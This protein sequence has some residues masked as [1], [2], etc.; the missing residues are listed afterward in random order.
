[1]ASELN[2]N[3]ISGHTLPL[4][5][6]ELVASDSAQT[7][8]AW[9]NF[10]GVPA[11]GTYVQSGTLVTVTITAHGMET[12]MICNLDFTS[13]TAVDILG[14]VITVTSVNTFTYVASTSISTSGNVTRNC[15]IRKSYNVSSITDNGTGD[16]TVNFATAMSDVNYSVGGVGGAP[17]VTGANDMTYFVRSDAYLAGSLRLITGASGIVYDYAVCNINIF[18]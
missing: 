18:R 13:G 9:V 15:Y 12:G 2:V 4:G 10:N 17:I 1:M 5:T 7:C 16:Y 14:A 3:K 8:K 6:A 11:T